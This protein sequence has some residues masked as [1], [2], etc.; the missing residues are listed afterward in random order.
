MNKTDISK[1]PL[2]IKQLITVIKSYIPPYSKPLYVNG[3]H[4]DAFVYISEGSCS[5]KFD[6]STEFTVNKGDILYLAY[7]AVYTMHI[8]TSNYRFIFCDFEF[9]C[10][11]QRKSGVYTPQNSSDT[12]NLFIRL[13]KS[14]D[15]PSHT[16]LAKSMS[17]LYNIYSE[18]LKLS[19]STLQKTQSIKIS[20]IKMYIDTHF[21]DTTLSVEI[22]A[23][24]AGISEVYLR[25]L[26]K[27]MYGVSPLEYIISMRIK[28][29]K[30]L[31]KYT[32]LTLEDCTLQSGF[33]SVQYFC[34]IFKKK[35][36]M[37]PSEYKKGL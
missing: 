8:H 34:R 28:K 36:G 21:Q 35:T 19:D 2:Y 31:M 30:E 18:I 16:S 4:S 6:D 24:K 27:S 7:H 17:I 11:Q 9:D 12:E 33:S 14:F 13:L 15:N 29:S 1:Q 25:K 23:A 26:F 22:L 20:E 5:Y 37:T 10:E 32:F 3:R